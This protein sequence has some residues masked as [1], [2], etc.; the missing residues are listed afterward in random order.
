M[1]WPPSNLN[2][3]CCENGCMSRKRR[4]WV[5][6]SK[7]SKLVSYVRFITPEL[8]CNLPSSSRPSRDAL[9]AKGNDETEGQTA[10]TGF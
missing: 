1:C 5:G 7:W 4:S 3:P 10:G 8:C 2:S 9:H 6:K